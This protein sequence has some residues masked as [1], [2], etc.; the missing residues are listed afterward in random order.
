MD[1]LEFDRF[2]AAAFEAFGAVVDKVHNEPG[3][4]RY[5]SAVDMDNGGRVYVE[6][7]RGDNGDS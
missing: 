7:R 2:N 5:W 3:H 4:R 1:R 6:Y